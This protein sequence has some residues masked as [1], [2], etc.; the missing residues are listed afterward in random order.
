[1]K[2]M[3]S[4][5]LQEC[6]RQQAVVRYKKKIHALKKCYEKGGKIYKERHVP[7]VTVS[8]AEIFPPETDCG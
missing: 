3:D 5:Q 7:I 8:T 1:M 6:Y 4:N 2:C